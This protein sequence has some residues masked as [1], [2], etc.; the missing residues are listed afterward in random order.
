MSTHCYVYG[1][2][3]PRT[4]RPFYIGISQNPWLRFDQHRYDRASAA[5]DFL[6][7]LTQN[8]GFERDEILAIFTICPDRRAALDLEYLFVTSTPDLLNRPYR[9]ERSYA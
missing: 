1:L 9:R 6:Q 5:W 2:F 7:F 3:D 4:L 8:C